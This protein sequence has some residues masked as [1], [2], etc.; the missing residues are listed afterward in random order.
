MEILH[1]MQQPDV[2]RVPKATRRSSFYCVLFSRKSLW[3]DQRRAGDI[4]GR[5]RGFKYILTGAFIDGA[6]A[7]TRTPNPQV[8]SLVLY[9]VELRAQH[10]RSKLNLASATDLDQQIINCVRACPTW[11]LCIHCSP[12]KHHH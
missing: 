7:G 3:L 5:P 11:L 4:E 9:P 10:G 2:P 6:P 8:R 12:T 1:E